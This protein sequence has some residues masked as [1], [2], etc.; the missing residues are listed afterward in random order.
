MDEWL[1]SVVTLIKVI[2]LAMPLLAGVA[3]WQARYAY[4]KWRGAQLHP[5]V[6]EER[7]LKPAPWA[8]LMPLWLGNLAGWIWVYSWKANG[9]QCLVL[10]IFG[11]FAFAG[12]VW[13]WR[14][15]SRQTVKI[16]RRAVQ[17]IM[18]NELYEIPWKDVS[19]F[20]CVKGDISIQDRN[21]FTMRIPL[22]IDGVEAVYAYLIELRPDILV[23]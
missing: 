11:I 14:L 22:H 3:M 5:D 9:M 6:C 1:F 8:Y 18:L 7:L 2:G 10:A 16:D 13:Y 15:L 23:A 17:H 21:G 20:K 4:I 12:A 19:E